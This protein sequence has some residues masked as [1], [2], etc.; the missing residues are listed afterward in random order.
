MPKMLLFFHLKMA[1]QKLTNFDV[2]LKM[3]A[4]M[5]QSQYGLTKLFRMLLNTTKQEP[6]QGKQRMALWPAR[7][8]D[9]VFLSILPISIF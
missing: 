7:E 9:H 1:T 5:T 6:S 8:L 2:L 4:D 3:H